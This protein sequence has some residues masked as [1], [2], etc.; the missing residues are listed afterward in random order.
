REGAFSWQPGGC[1]AEVRYDF[2]RTHATAG[3]LGEAVQALREAV[4]AAWGELPLL[5]ADPALKALQ[6]H[7]EV[8]ALVR[9]VESRGRL[10]PLPEWFHGGGEPR[11]ERTL[12]V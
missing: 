4:A 5:H 1:D 7:P 3:Q 8:E 6:G 10:P 12:P 9:L 11:D 2:A